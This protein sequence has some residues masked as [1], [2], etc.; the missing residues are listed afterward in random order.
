MDN[1]FFINFI[2]FEH[3][4]KRPTGTNLGFDKWG[5]RILWA[6]TSGM[7]MVSFVHAMFNAYDI[8]IALIMHVG[9]NGIGAWS[10]K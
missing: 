8:P 9:G 2:V 3:V 10:T 5:M 7:H 1:W 4:E 6:G